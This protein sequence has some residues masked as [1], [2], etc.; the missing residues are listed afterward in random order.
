MRLHTITTLPSH[1]V[2]AT[3]ASSCTLR[4]VP[5]SSIL[6]ASSISLSPFR[7]RFPLPDRRWRGIRRQ[8]GAAAALYVYVRGDQKES[9]MDI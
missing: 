3:K 1:V 4:I 6:R 2:L 5:I 7:T 9:D 8:S